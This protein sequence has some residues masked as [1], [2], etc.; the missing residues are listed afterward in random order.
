[1]RSFFTISGV[2][3]ERRS[4]GAF[5][6][7]AAT[8]TGMDAPQELAPLAILARGGNAASVMRH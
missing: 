3:A 8:V 5:S 1:M 6:S 7:T 2:I 4:P